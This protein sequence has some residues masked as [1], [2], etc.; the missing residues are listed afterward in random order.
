M[1]L[2]QLWQQFKLHKTHLSTGYTSYTLL[3]PSKDSCILQRGDSPVCTGDDSSNA[4][5][6]SVKRI[7]EKPQPDW[8]RATLDRFRME[9]L[10]NPSRIHTN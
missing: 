4:A 7:L 1:L 3:S 9:Y 5:N 8:Q 10:S 2:Q 6:P